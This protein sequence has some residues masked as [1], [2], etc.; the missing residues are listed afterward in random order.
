MVDRR[1]AKH[2]CSEALVVGIE[3]PGPA[4]SEY[5]RKTEYEV[6]KVTE[7]DVFEPDLKKVCGGGINFFLDR[8]RALSYD[9]MVGDTYSGFDKQWYDNGQLASEGGVRERSEGRCL[10]ILA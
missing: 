9:L 7:A 1:F 6:G 10:E 8:G 4:V 5:D 3:P 2:R